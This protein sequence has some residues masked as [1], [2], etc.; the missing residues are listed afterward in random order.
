MNDTERRVAQLM[1]GLDLDAA[2][3]DDVARVAEELVAIGREG[4]A[5]L[6]RGA[7]SH[8]HFAHGGYVPNEDVTP[9][10]P[11]LPAPRRDGRRSR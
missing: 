7:V 11:P 8:L 5:C 1:D 4:V 9:G 2:S 10:R 3:K 6:V